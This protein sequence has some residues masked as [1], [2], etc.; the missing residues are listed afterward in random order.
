MQIEDVSRVRLSARGSSQQQ[1]DL[2]IGDRLLGQIVINDQR[3]L[4]AVA[5]V[6]THGATRKR[7]EVLH[8]RRIRSVGGHHDRVVHRAVLFE[9]ADH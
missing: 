3:V 6:L 9:L 8:R 7:R 2:T 1:R 4:T 5:V